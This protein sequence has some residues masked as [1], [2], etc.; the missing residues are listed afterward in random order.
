META[1]GA[2]RATGSKWDATGAKRDA[3]GAAGVQRDAPVQ[4]DATGRFAH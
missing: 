1:L 3:T 4:G 2:T